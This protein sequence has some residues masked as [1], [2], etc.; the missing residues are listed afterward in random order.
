MFDKR[1]GYS[2][3]TDPKKRRENMD[4]SDIVAE[5]DH[6]DH[7]RQFSPSRKSIAS[8]EEKGLK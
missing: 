1:F 4:Y 5:F 8:G 3:A 2:N 6:E 7:S